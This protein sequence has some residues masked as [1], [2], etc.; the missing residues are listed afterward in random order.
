M[1]TRKSPHTKS[2][3]RGDH[4]K[5]CGRKPPTKAVQE[6]ARRTWPG[7]GGRPRAIKDESRAIAL[8]R[9]LARFKASRAECAAALGVSLGTLN[10]FFAR[11]PAAKEAYQD[12]LMKG[13]VSLRR[14][15]KMLLRKRNNSAATLAIFL[16]CQYLGQRRNP[17]SRPTAQDALKALLE[18]INRREQEAVRI[19]SSRQ[20]AKDPLR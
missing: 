18:E 17:A 1:T 13:N 10:A 16:G 7:R 2:K 12:G 5:E 9:R 3:G 14:K 4:V 11:V 8:L 20:S 6:T 19:H 15:Q